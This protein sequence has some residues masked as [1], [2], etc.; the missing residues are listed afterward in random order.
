MYCT[1]VS[2]LDS[3]GEQRNLLKYRTV[4]LGGPLKRCARGRYELAG[5]ADSGVR[6]LARWGRCVAV[7]LKCSGR[8]W[9]GAPLVA[10]SSLVAIRALSCCL[11]RCGSASVLSP[12]RCTR[13]LNPITADCR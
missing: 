12:G 11:C 9:C 10:D 4:R 2:K 6:V 8:W 1:V 7:L 5:D 3:K 13:F